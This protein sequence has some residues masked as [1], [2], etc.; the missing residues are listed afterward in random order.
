MRYRP[1]LVSGAAI[2]ALLAAA[3]PAA[4]QSEVK[5]LGRF[6]DW[7]AYTYQENG[8][9]VCYVASSPTRRQGNV[10]SRGDV[11][12][13]VTH[14][15][16]YND[17]GVVTV[18]AGYAYAPDSTVEVKIGRSDFRFFTRDE[19][20]WANGSD[21]R[22]TVNAMKRGNTMTVSGRSK[23]GA[24]TSD[25]FSLMGLTKAYQAISA[26]CKVKG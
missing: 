7:S 9:P 16:E 23:S 12:F 10:K 24:A 3:T 19:T 14:R 2:L 26:A 11:F 17:V 6:G 25:T 21:D 13:L 5:S 4:A 1:K 18:V 15:P 8:N 20:A 22:A